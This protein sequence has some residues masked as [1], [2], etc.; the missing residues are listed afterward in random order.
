M[1]S[2]CTS[3][4]RVGSELSGR[5]S[6][7]FLSQRTGTSCLPL[8]LGDAAELTDCSPTQSQPQKS[9]SNFAP[10]NRAIPPPVLLPSA[11]SSFGKRRLDSPLPP[12][13]RITSFPPS[14]RAQR[15]P[16]LS[17]PP[18]STRLFFP[19]SF[20]LSSRPHKPSQPFTHLLSSHAQ[21]VYD[22][23]T[24]TFERCSTTL[25]GLSSLDDLSRRLR[26]T[27][28]RI[29]LALSLFL[30][31]PV[32]V[33]SSVLS[34]SNKSLTLFPPSFLS[35]FSRSTCHT[36]RMAFSSSSFLVLFSLL[37]SGMSPFLYFLY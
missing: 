15:Y 32:S 25:A 19:F 13:K 6:R 4:R 26:S 18:T 16:R 34:S 23:G 3:P 21:R 35:L 30:P 9:S 31:L 5:T 33:L 37:L 28:F 29:S 17:R 22:D 12:D 11:R 2:F 10:P 24:R 36:P 14:S 7:L 8:S 1:S 27:C 20:F